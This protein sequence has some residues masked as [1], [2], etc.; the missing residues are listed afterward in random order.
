MKKKG[1]KLVLTITNNFRKYAEIVD[2][3]NKEA[4]TVSNEVFTKWIVGVLFH[5]SFTLKER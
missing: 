4:E 1:N 2:N 3:Q 5:P